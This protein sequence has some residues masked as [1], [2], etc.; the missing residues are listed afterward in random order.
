[1]V[2]Q[3]QLEPQAYQDIQAAITY[4]ELKQKGLG[5]RFHT[6]VLN[7]FDTIKITPFFQIRYNEIRCYHVRPFP[8]LVHYKVNEDE[9]M[10][11]V[12]GVVSTYLNPETYYFQ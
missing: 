11:H 12:L 8:Y 1:M 6:I 9:K 7:A 2:Y 3:I 4:Y 5:N 10:I